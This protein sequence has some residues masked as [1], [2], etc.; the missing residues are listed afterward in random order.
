[1]FSGLSG[2]GLGQLAAIS[3]LGRGSFCTGHVSEKDEAHENGGVG[4]LLL[5]NQDELQTDLNLSKI[6]QQLQAVGMW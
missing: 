1:M 6:L 4:R 5:G 3:S 2:C